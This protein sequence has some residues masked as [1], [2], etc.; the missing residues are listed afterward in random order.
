MHFSESRHFIQEVNPANTMAYDRNL[1]YRFVPGFNPTN[2]IDKPIWD[3]EDGNVIRYTA[4]FD[5]YFH[6]SSKRGNRQQD[7]NKSILFLKG[8]TARNLSRILEPLII[9]VE[10]TQN[11]LDDDGSYSDGF[12]PPYLR[13][14]ELAQKIAERCK[15]EPYDRDIGGRPRVHNFTYDIDASTPKSDSEDDTQRYTE[16]ID[17]HMQG[18]LVPAITQ[19]CRPNGLPGRRMPNTT[20]TRKPDPARRMRPDQPRVICNACGKKGHGANTC[21]FL[22]MSV[23]LQR[24]MKHGIVN[25][26]TIADAEQHWVDRAKD[27]F[28][29]WDRAKDSSFLSRGT[30]P[31]KVFQAFAERSGLSL[32][33]MEDEIDWLCWPTDLD[34]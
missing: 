32:E 16:P 33:Q 28:A 30:T 22:T 31:S 15:V 10:S 11:K 19:A 2:T 1:L 23:F 17:G 5:L 29:P 9:A 18:Y 7:V 12:L 13:V 21:D 14:D 8:I 34:E 4:A 26:D 6:L 20:Y 25:K 27:S 24:F 3:G